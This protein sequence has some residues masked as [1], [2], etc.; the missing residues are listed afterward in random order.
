MPFDSTQTQSLLTHSSRRKL[1]HDKVALYHGRVPGIRNL[2]LSVVSII[3]GL[4]GVNILV[5]VVVGC[6]LVRSI[7][8]S[9]GDGKREWDIFMHIRVLTSI[10]IGQSY[11]STYIGLLETWLYRSS[12]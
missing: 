12:G 5:W 10:V 9:A 6:V 4:I 1:I 11:V 8:V 7:A 2:P 3:V